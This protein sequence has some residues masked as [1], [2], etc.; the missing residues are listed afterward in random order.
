L[1]TS[2][3]EIVLLIAPYPPFGL[4]TVSFVGLSAY[5]I[6]VGIY[7]ST[8]SV[9]LN[10]SLR[11]LISRSLEEHSKFLHGIGSAQMDQGIQ[12][13][14]LKISKKNSDKIIEE[15]GIE[16]SITDDDVKKYLNEVLQEIK[17][18]KNKS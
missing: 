7:S 6:L 1:F 8:I 12:A 16:P 2:N 15:T 9:S 18:D 10:I 5:F 4:A 14:V 3:Q 17:G 13:A 11:K